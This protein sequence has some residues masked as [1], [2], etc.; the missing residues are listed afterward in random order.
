MNKF[1]KRLATGVLSLVILVIVGVLIITLLVDPNRFKSE[2]ETTAKT[3]GVT[4]AIEGELAWQLVPL[5]LRV[6][7]VNFTLQDQSMAGNADQLSLGVNLSALF[8]LLSQSTNFPISSLSVNNGRILYALPNSLPLQFS[9]IDLSIEE[10]NASG[11]KFPISLKLVAPNA[12]KVTLNADTGLSIN[13]Q[14]IESFSI[15]DLDLKINNIEIDGYIEATDNLTKIQGQINTTAF[16]LLKQFKLAKRFVPDLLVP[17]MTD[18]KALTHISFDS[19]FDIKMGD[20]SSIQTQI[21][22]DGQPIEVDIELNQPKYSLSTLISGKKLNL[23]GY[24]TTTESSYNSSLLFAPL[25]IPMAIWHGQSQLE[26]NL[27]TIVLG[28]YKLSNFYANLFG[29]QNI[30]KLTS[31]N[32]DIFDGHVHAT[33]TLNLQSEKPAF[34]VDSSVT[35]INLESVTQSLEDLKVDGRLNAQVSIQGS[36]N[37]KNSFIKSLKGN[38]RVNI[39]NPVYQGINLE[40]T[41]CNAAALFSGK[42]PSQRTWA[43]NTKLD[44]I[45][46]NM[47]FSGDRLLVSDYQTQLGNIAIYGNG[48]L[49]IKSNR[50]ALNT[51]ALANK[52]RSSE[53][54]CTIN[55]FVVKRKI[56]FRCKGELGQ[57]FDC[58]PDNNLIKSLLLSPKL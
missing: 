54:G 24:Q 16:N 12:I 36:G 37:Q 47:R 21:N 2:I 18:P 29:N 26:L 20:V 33:A 25:A 32:G 44:D 39:M 10:L 15:S 49:N 5:G 4:L 17:Q 43:E 52:S 50:Y 48:N 51:T 6:E 27:A 42:P 56:P 9:Q 55:Q 30:F 14:R 28:E 19:Y 40:Q 38:G 1:F 13:Q 57:K 34:S 41:F 7:R 23:T 31:L 35:N 8:S 46:A 22:L 53:N 45:T 3:A 58:K 11:K